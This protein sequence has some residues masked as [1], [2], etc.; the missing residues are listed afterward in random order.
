MNLRIRGGAIVLAVATVMCALQ[1]EPS[2]VT[3]GPTN[4]AKTRVPVFKVDP[5]WPKQEGHFGDKGNWIFGAIGGIDVDR[6]NDHVWIIQRPRTLSVEPAADEIGAS[7]NPPTQDCCIPAPTV[8]EFD[9]AGNFIQGWG[10][11]GPGYDWPE[12]EHGIRIDYRGNVWIT[13]NNKKDNQILKFTKSG[14]FLLQIGHPGQS[15][16]SSDTENFNEPTNTWVYPKTNEVFVSDGY[17]N[18]RVIVFDADTG[19]YK[20]MWGAYGNKP[21]DTIPRIRRIPFNG[22]DDLAVQTLLEGPPPQQFN[23]VHDIVISNDNLVYVADR[24]NNRIQ[25]FKP[26]GT[27]VKEAFVA[28]D[29]MTPTGSTM[30]LALSPDNRQEFMYVLGGDRHIRILNRDSLQVLGQFGRM[31]H[32][33]GQLFHMHGIAVDSKGNLYEEEAASEGRRIQKYVFEGFSSAQSN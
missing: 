1:V 29:N 13:G 9:A 15:R 21:D 11:S 2:R 26:D 22:P 19:V 30:S 17:I 5:F 8:M 31:G 16:G 25:V 27:F 23:L 12:T 20:R 18:R 28:K 10:G 4:K 32:F 3:A 33:P 14:K 6:S 7:H 24:S